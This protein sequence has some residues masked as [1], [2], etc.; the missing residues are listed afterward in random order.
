M[1]TSVGIPDEQ[2]AQGALSAQALDAGRVLIA[3][4]RFGA[5]PGIPLDQATSFFGFYMS[6][7]PE[8]VSLRIEH[9]GLEVARRDLSA[10]PP[11]VEILDVMSPEPERFEVRLSADDADGDELFFAVGYS[12]DDERYWLLQPQWIT[13]ARATRDRRPCGDRRC[14]GAGPR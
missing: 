9:S 1:F 11:S 7:P 3:E 6:L 2:S 4:H 14:A 5:P 13:S 12:P 8:T 10:S